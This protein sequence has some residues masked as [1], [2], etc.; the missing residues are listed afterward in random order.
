MHVEPSY[1]PETF[2]LLQ[3][4]RVK[5]SSN[6]PV[7]TCNQGQQCE[8]SLS[9][10]YF[11]API[12]LQSWDGRGSD[13]RLF[14]YR[15]CGALWWLLLITN[16]KLGFPPVILRSACACQLEKSAVPS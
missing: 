10:I 16:G 6:A 4:F 15:E 8:V 1:A 7:L 12:K 2:Q 14:P 13:L 3:Y 5:I 11:R 9:T